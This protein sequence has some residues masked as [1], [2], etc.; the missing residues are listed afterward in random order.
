MSST[1]TRPVEADRG[2]NAYGADQEED[3]TMTTT[4]ITGASQGLGFHAA[5]RLVVLGHDVWVTARDPKAGERAAHQ[6]GAHFAQ[7]DVTDDTSV[8]DAA[9]VIAKAGGLDVLIN[10]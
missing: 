10:N 5:R 6:I 9:Q 8:S 4:L 2:S 1:P 3:P 7:L